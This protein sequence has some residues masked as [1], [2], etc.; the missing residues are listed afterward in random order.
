MSM[1]AQNFL[2]KSTKFRMPLRLDRLHNVPRHKKRRENL[3]KK[4]TF[5]PLSPAARADKAE[6]FTSILSSFFL[7]RHVMWIGLTLTALKTISMKRC[8]E[9]NG[10]QRASEV[11]KIP[12]GVASKTAFTLPHWQSVPWVFSSLPMGQC[13]STSVTPNW[14]QCTTRYYGHIWI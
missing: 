5:Y 14:P 1:V 12:K 7:S 4:L 11:A 3:G 13:Q 10:L 2:V 9:Q 6:F 8:Q